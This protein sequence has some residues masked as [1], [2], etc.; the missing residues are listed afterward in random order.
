MDTATNLGLLEL[1]KEHLKQPEYLHVLLNPLPVYG[2]GLGILALIIA[3]ALRSRPAQIT[4]LV[5]VFLSSASA[6]PVAEFGEQGYDR[7]E[8]MSSSTGYAWLDAHAQR[9]TKAMFVFYTLAAVSLLALVVPWKFPKAALWL[10]TIT[11][12]LSIIA[13]GVG[14]WI[15]Y[16][17]GQIRHKE[18][19]Y[20]MPPE[21][22]GVYDKMRD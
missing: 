10:N 18:F 5:I 6:W 19:Q 2:V 20:G 12:L 1:A 21:K 3:M 22:P 11:L 13:L 8:S 9:A 4:A 14:I 17:G 15:A 16:A 7:I